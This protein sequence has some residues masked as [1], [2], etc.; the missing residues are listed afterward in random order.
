MPQPG[1][2]AVVDSE[3]GPLNLFDKARV[4]QLATE[5]VL[6]AELGGTIVLVNFGCRW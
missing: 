2:L 3:A 4:G 6:N 5:Q 1:R